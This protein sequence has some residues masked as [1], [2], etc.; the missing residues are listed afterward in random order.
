MKIRHS[1]EQ[2]ICILLLIA[3]SDGPLKSH[4]LSEILKVSDSYL[5][6]ITRQLVVSGLITSKASKRG[7][8]VLNRETKD[9]SFLD[10]FDAIEGK[11]NFIETTH[12]MDKAFD[13][14]IKVAETENVF[15]EYLNNAEEQYRSKLKEITLERIIK[16]A[17][18]VEKETVHVD[19]VLK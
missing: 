8:F 11:E 12:L 10:I 5:K 18:K 16:V 17:H 3:S 6:K 9:I 15:M 4:Q 7:G 1:F 13:S 2:A 19:S 14:S